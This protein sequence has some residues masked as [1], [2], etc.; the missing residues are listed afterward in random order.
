MFPGLQEHLDLASRLESLPA[1]LLSVEAQGASSPSPSPMVPQLS[2]RSL[3]QQQQ[4]QLAWQAETEA[5]RQLGE[6][7]SQ[8]SA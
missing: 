5:H 1:L 6:L 3:Q 4:Q 7:S 8:Q 2:L